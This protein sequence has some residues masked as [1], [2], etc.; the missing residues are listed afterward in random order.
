[1]S[2]R[3]RPKGTF[4][5]EITTANPNWLSVG[6]MVFVHRLFPSFRIKPSVS[7]S[8]VSDLGVDDRLA[9]LILVAI[10]LEQKEAEE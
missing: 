5:V 9:I 4:V 1:M 6:E 7:K 2:M 10:L 8:E 3:R